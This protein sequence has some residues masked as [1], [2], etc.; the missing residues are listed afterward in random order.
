M[1]LLGTR[2]L[3]ALL[4]YSESEI[5]GKPIELLSTPEDRAAATMKAELD[6]ALD[7]GS[8][9]DERWM[10]RAD[11][12]RIWC[13][14]ITNAIYDDA[15]RI[16]GFVKVL[17]D[18]TDRRRAHEQIRSSLREKEALLQEIHHRVK[19]NLQV[20]ISLLNLQAGYITDE[21]ARIAL[22]ETTNRLYSIAEIHEMLYSSEEF[23]RVDFSEYLERLAAQ[24]FALYGTPA[25]RVRLHV[26]RTNLPL[27]IRQAIPCGLIANEL[28][29]NALKYAF[30]GNR[31]GTIAISCNN[32]LNNHCVLRIAD[33][34]VGL[35]P[36][37]NWR[38]AQSMGLRLVRVLADQLGG[39]L[40]LEPT[41]VGVSFRVQFPR[42]S[43]EGE[44]HEQ[45]ASS[46]RRG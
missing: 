37:V 19:N 6:R 15:G 20:V 17:G 30:P 5:L 18:E 46:G 24:L 26:E 41:N 7:K 33:D 12:R 29:M 34:G 8:A 35:P 39:T 40:E 23:A 11:G 13:R 36:E 14:W 45:A 1:S 9:E 2:V 21:Q 28:L 32:G 22:E 27:P 25:D 16:R 42:A 43:S 44:V 31:S 3:S 4:G 10:L 38:Q